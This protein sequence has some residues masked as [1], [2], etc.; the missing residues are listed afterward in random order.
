VI[1]DRGEALRR[2]NA[3]RAR[4]AANDAAAA[5]LDLSGSRHGAVLTVPDWGGNETHG[6]TRMQTQSA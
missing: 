6:L 4:I 5:I 2:R 3:A 1:V